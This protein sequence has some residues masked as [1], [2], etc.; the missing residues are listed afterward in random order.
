MRGSQSAGDVDRC[1]LIRLVLYNF[2]SPMSRPSDSEMKK[3]TADKLVHWLRDPEAIRAIEEHLQ[4]TKDTRPWIDACMKSLLDSSRP[5][6]DRY[7][8]MQVLKQI[9]LLQKKEVGPHLKEKWLGALY[10][11]VLKLQEE[12]KA[13]A[14]ASLGEA[15]RLWRRRLEHLILNCFSA[16]QDIFDGIVDFF[17]FFSQMMILTVNFPPFD[18]FK[19]NIFRDP[20]LPYTPPKKEAPVDEAEEE[21]AQANPLHLELA[22]KLM[23][24]RLILYEMIENNKTFEECR[25]RS[26]C[27]HLRNF[28]RL[29]LSVRRCLQ[30][31]QR[32][33][34]AADREE[35]QV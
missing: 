31:A 34:S 28:E 24:Y 18:E 35:A 1:L 8:S 32:H 21:E 13:G 12:R 15:D 33:D 5:A 9:T 23:Q 20:S 27:R 29:Q 16:W 3:V 30:Q 4:S 11:S 10:E 17:T 14:A 26:N 6:E 7:R 2:N 19:L 22:A 25:F